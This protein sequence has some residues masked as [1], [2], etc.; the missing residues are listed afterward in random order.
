MND[1]LNAQASM[2]Y[3][4]NAIEDLV[5]I[6]AKFKPGDKVCIKKSKFKNLSLNIQGKTRLIYT[7][8][9]TAWTNLGIMH[10]LEHDGEELGIPIHEESLYLTPIYERRKLNL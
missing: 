10:T 9:G 3:F 6:S 1:D 4:L 2:D 5:K 8:K 7:I